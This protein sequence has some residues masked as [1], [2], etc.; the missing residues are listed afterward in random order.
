MSDFEHPAAEAAHYMRKH[1]ELL[2]EENA[3]RRQEARDA[4]YL[5]GS[6]QIVATRKGAAAKLYAQL[7]AVSGEEGEKLPA[8]YRAKKRA[9]VLEAL[10]RVNR[11]AVRDFQAWRQPLERAPATARVPGRSGSA[12]PPTSTPRT[13]A[14]ASAW[15]PMVT[16]SSSSAP[17]PFWRLLATSA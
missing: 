15:T 8:E 7:Q 13:S 12:P 10:E 11:T 3:R 17:G 9:E 5:A 1:T 4:A 2:E 16:A 6:Q 14:T